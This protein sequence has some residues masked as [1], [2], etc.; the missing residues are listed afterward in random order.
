MAKRTAR[1]EVR[2]QVARTTRAERRDVETAY[3]VPRFVEALR[4][5]A[6]P[7]EQ[8]RRFEI[9]VAGERVRVAADATISL[10]HER[11]ADEE[12]LNSRCDG[13]RAASR[14]QPLR[15]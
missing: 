9:R 6:D 7:L 8:G 1:T 13:G 12:E 2:A 14:P 11:S 15:P 3:P 10:E 5:L 4:R